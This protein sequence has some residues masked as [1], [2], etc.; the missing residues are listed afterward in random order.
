MNFKHYV[1]MSSIHLLLGNQLLCH[2]VE[3]PSQLPL[4]PN[5]ACQ[6]RNFFVKSL[7]NINRLLCLSVHTSVRPSC[8]LLLLGAQPELKIYNKFHTHMKLVD[9]ANPR[10][11]CEFGLNLSGRCTQSLIYIIK[12]GFVV[13]M[14]FEQWNEF[15]LQ[16][17]VINTCSTLVTIT[18]VD[19]SIGVASMIC[20][21]IIENCSKTNSAIDM[22]VSTLVEE[23]R[24]NVEECKEG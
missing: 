1:G 6:G 10:N 11:T 21:Y 8:S 14:F 12:L 23:A 19:T 15:D 3:F 13:R 9:H 7:V 2:Q 5:F 20:Y 4:H 16:T 24:A 17:S 18:F 22:T